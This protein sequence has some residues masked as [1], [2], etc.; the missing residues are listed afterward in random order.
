MPTALRTSLHDRHAAAGAKVGAFAGWDMPLVY[1]S[2]REEHRAVRERSGVFDVS[3]MGQLEVSGRGARAY[4]AASLTNDLSRIGPGQGQYTLLLQED[5]GIIDDLIVYALPDRYLLVV[6]AGNVAACRDWLAGR[7]PD[8]VEVADRSAEIGMLAVQGPA[9]EAAVGPL[10]G[11]PVALGLEYFEITEG[12]LAGVPS[13]IAR[14]GYTGEPGVE[15][16]CPWAEVPRLWDALLA[17]PEPPAPAGLAARDTLRLEMGYPLYGQDL[18]RE[19]TPI[20]AG[21]R[22]ACDLDGAY[23]GAD[24]LRRQA[25]EGT[26]ERLAIFTLVEPGIPRPG[27]EVRAGDEAVGTVTSGTL[28]PTL[29]VGIGMAYL[30]VRPGPGRARHRRRRARQAQGGP[31]GAA[32]PGRDLPEERLSVAEA[33][34]PENLRY[35]REHDWVRTE[36]DGEAVFGITF[37]AQDA[38]GE[39]VYYD[40]PEVGRRIVKDAPYGELESVKAVSDIYAPAG[41]E[42]LAVNQT[43]VDGPEVVNADPYGAGWLI[44]VRISDPAELDDLMDAEAYRAYLDGLG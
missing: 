39:V 11:S 15:I 3:H 26:A 21:L 7:A 25:A 24:V 10:P 35:H 41:G 17:G 23:P 14:T 16:M 34:Y 28:S 31:H 6:N 22:W 18:S 37:Y 4:L 20:E 8:G 32:T 30:P 13:L 38:L 27:C 2:V 44:R 33:S 36:D 43:V 42:V 40:P 19:R 5:G 29:G 12:A 1:T 9:W